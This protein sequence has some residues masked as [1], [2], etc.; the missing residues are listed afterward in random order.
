MSASALALRAEIDR[1]RQENMELRLALVR[2]TKQL[3]ETLEEFR[4]LRVPFFR[5]WRVRR[6]MARRKAAFET[7][8]AEHQPEPV[9]SVPE[10]QGPPLIIVPKR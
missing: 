4:L 9:V 5:R 7:A 10:H 2:T 6:L 8:V 3:G 1:L